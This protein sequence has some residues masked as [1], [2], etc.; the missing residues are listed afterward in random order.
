MRNKIVDAAEL[1]IQE[2]QQETGEDLFSQE[3]IVTG[4]FNDAIMIIT[5]ESGV[6]HITVFEGD[7]YRIDHTISTDKGEKT[8]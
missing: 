4:V 3:C 7:P 5:A 1:L 6:F 8:R 2:H